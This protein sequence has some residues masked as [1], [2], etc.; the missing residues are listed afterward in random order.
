MVYN[1]PRAPDEGSNWPATSIR[2]ELRNLADESRTLCYL[3]SQD[4][5]DAG[6]NLRND[7]VTLDPSNTKQGCMTG[8]YKNNEPQQQLEWR[9]QQT[10]NV[11]FNTKS[12]VLCVNQTW[13][14]RGNEGN[15]ITVVKSAA[16]ELE[17]DC[18]YTSSCEPT[19]AT[20]STTSGP[21]LIAP[22]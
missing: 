18:P 15:D 6:V 12:H 22:T 3:Q 17:F 7:G 9:W 19:E 16:R 1:P 8:W 11:A 2:V 10:A 14:C 4:M 21:I 13:S 20:Y 5:S